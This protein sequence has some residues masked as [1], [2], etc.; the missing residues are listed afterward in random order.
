M[1]ASAGLGTFGIEWSE[2]KHAIIMALRKAVTTAINKAGESFLDEGEPKWV[3]EQIIANELVALFAGVV[4][5]LNLEPKVVPQMF[6][7]Y[8]AR[9]LRRG[10][11][12]E[13]KTMLTRTRMVGFTGRMTEKRS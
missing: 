9:T 10:R 6:S 1:T 7:E 12:I 3:T 11:S 5:Q 13:T 4:V 8:Y 2:R